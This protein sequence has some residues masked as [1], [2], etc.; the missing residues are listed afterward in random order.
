MVNRRSPPWPDDIDSLV[1]LA[2]EKTMEAEK[3]PM[4]RVEVGVQLTVDKEIQNYN[5]TYRG[6]DKATNVL[7]FALMDGD[8]E[9]LAEDGPLPF[10]D[11]ILAYETIVKEATDQGKP[12]LNHVTHLVV[13]GT[14]HLLGYDHERSTEEAQLQEAREITILAQLNL[15]NPYG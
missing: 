14:L 3:Q 10:G 13:H 4:E 1:E 12:F 5:H 6:I 7:S 11:I 2:I 8:N 9:I 15:P